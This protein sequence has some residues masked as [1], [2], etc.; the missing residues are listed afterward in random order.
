MKIILISLDTLRASRLSSYGYGK[1]TSP[2]MDRIASEG[3]LFE[4]AFAADIPTEVAHTGIFTGKV[5]L[6]TGVVSHGSE[7]TQLPKSVEWLPALLRSA[8]FTTAAVDNLYQLK[9]WFARGYKY[10]LNSVGG[11][12]WIDGRTVNDMALPWIEQHQ[13]E[14]F[15]LFLHY[16]DAH[17]PY[18]PPQSYIPQFYDQSKDPFDPRNKSMEQAYN[19]SAYP[20]F[21]HHH[22]D[23]VGPV[24]D[25]D[26]YDSLYDAEIRYL[27][28]CLK[29]LDEHLLKLGIQ[30]DTLMILFGDH[31][32]SLTEHDIYW[33]HCGLYEPTVHVPLIMRWPGRISAGRRVPGLVQQVDLLPTLLEAVR[34]EAPADIDSS[35]L[36]DPAGLDGQSLWKSIRGEEDGTHEII[37]LSECAWQAARGIRTE[38]YKLICTYDS[39]PF[40]RP[41]RELYDLLV[42]PAETVN[43]AD[44]EPE[45]AD[46]LEGQLNDWTAA[47]LSGNKDP[48]ERQLEE[49]GLPF[50]RRIEQILDAAGMSWEEWSRDPDRERFDQ[51]SRSHD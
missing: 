46:L 35:K 47:K 18:L 40:N 1:A 3:V 29:E 39:G 22:Y 36:A 16:W 14:D 44:K 6:T 31:G 27:D 23:L 7:L 51:A 34:A 28:D 10:Y 20:F 21:K 9:E 48:M 38:R 43:L 11:N 45:L 8:G 4:R 50:R 12:R 32:E 24:T 5:G 15:F 37:Y 13:E 42:D 17:T 25:S 30:E 26:Y 33:D 19:H 41:A 2:H 49:K